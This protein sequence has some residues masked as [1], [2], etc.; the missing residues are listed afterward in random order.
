MKPREV[1]FATS[2][3]GKFREVEALASQFGLKI[4]MVPLKPVEIQHENLAEI[5]KHAVRQVLRRLRAPVFVEDAGLFIEALNGF[6][7][8]YSSYVY[9]TLGV[10]GIL[11]LLE[12]NSNRRAYFL[13]AIAFARPRMKVKVFLGRSDG[14]IGWK[15]KG[16]SGFGFDPIFH[17]E[18][19]KQT[20]A[21]MGLENKNRYSHR[22]EAFRKLAEWLL[23]D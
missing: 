6:P 10:Q 22:A 4:R 12:G 18:G 2:N 20:F 19:V 23:R 14:V 8:P 7:G 16:E 1:F 17:P 3:Q 15:A 21:E 11:K 5:A 9:K 13:S